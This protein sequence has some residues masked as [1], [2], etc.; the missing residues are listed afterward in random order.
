[1]T[2]SSPTFF[3]E[4]SAVGRGCGGRC[5]IRGGR[6]YF[7]VLNEV[8][9]Q[10]PAHAPLKGPLDEPGRRSLMNGCWHDEDPKSIRR[11]VECDP[12]YVSWNKS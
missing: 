5:H 10:E 11:Y 9:W 12:D 1:M 7:D 2:F 8:G 4:R 6:Q 3:G